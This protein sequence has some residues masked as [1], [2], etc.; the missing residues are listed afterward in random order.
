MTFCALNPLIP[1]NGSFLEEERRKRRW[2]PEQ[3]AESSGH[4]RAEAS[5]LLNPCNLSISR[6]LTWFESASVFQG[7]A[8]SSQRLAELGREKEESP[9]KT[10]EATPTTSE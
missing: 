9:R 2:R 5:G 8:S 7:E 4:V 10:E 6:S 1:V 3:G